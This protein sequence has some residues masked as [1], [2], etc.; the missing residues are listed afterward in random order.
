M[1][2]P[3]SQLR[4]IHLQGDATVQGLLDGQ[5]DRCHATLRDE[6]FDLVEEPLIVRSEIGVVARFRLGDE[7]RADAGQAV[8]AIMFGNDTCLMSP[9]LSMK[10]MRNEL[11]SVG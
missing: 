3:L 5:I 9:F 2:A 10:R 1:A 7:P 11:S 6:A 8:D 4:N